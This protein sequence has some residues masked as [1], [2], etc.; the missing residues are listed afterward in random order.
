MK[1]SDNI[2]LWAWYGYIVA[3]IL[4]K[5]Y[6]EKIFEDTH[7]E[8]PVTFNNFHYTDDTANSFSW[9]CLTTINSN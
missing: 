9:K 2:L 7:A 3:P 6:S 8:P 4:L 1:K 5:I